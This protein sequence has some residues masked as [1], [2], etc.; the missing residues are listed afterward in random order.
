MTGIQCDQSITADPHG[1]YRVEFFF[2]FFSIHVL[3]N[4]FESDP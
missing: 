3:F 4:L 2:P 1:A